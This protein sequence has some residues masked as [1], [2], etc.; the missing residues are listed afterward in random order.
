M[1]EVAVRGAMFRLRQQFGQFIR[2][3]IAETVANPDEV[4]DEVRHLLAV[5]G[6]RE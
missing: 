1:S 2:A 6:H 5:V 3:E 4:D